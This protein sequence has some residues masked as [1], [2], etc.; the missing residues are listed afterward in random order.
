MII[1][2]MSMTNVKKVTSCCYKKCNKMS[3]RHEWLSQVIMSFATRSRKMLRFNSQLSFTKITKNITIDFWNK[4]PEFSLIKCYWIFIEIAR[5]SFTE[6]HK[7]FHSEFIV[8][9]LLNI[10]DPLF[11]RLRRLR[12]WLFAWVSLVARNF[13]SSPQPGSKDHV[14]DWAGFIIWSCSRLY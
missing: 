9:L 5:M 12:T 2:K 11:R 8:W 14:S 13:N 10:H 1:T 3:Q 6:I 4:C 7:K